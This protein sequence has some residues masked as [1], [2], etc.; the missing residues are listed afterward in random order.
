[1][2][3]RSWKKYNGTQRKVGK[4]MRERRDQIEVAMVDSV[5]K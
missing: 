2:R 4:T 5:G 3:E 1:M